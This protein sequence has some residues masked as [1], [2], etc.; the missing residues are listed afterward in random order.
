M[1][2]KE[3]TKILQDKYAT[4]PPG[5]QLRNGNWVLPTGE[6]IKSKDV[7]DDSSEEE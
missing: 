1:L 4:P 3:I 6:K 2:V 5:A 7:I